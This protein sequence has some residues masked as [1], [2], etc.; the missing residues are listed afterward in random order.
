M[1]GIAGYLGKN[2]IE[3]NIINRT[4]EALNHRGPDSKGFY[5]T[6]DDKFNNLYLLHTRLNILDIEKRSNQPYRLGPFT[7]IFNGEIYNYLE[8]KSLLEKE[9]VKFQTTGDTEVLAKALVQW[10]LDITLD[11]LE[12]MWAFAFYDKNS[13]DLYLSRDRFGEKP[14]YFTNQDDGIYLHLRQNHYFNF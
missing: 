4:L 11:K 6:T 2:S 3:D 9:G 13:G 7:L 12:G 10:G 5:H 14:L 1:C 8:I